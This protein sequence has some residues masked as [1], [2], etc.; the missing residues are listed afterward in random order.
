[1]SVTCGGEDSGRV[2]LVVLQPPL[3]LPHQTG[4]EHA[5]SCREQEPD[6][7]ELRVPG[8]QAG[9]TTDPKGGRKAVRKPAPAWSLRADDGLQETPPCRPQPL[10]MQRDGT[11]RG[12]G[13]WTAGQEADSR[14]C[15]P[16]RP[17][18]RDGLSKRQEACR[19]RDWGSVRPTEDR[20]ARGAL[21]RVRLVCP[22]RTPHVPTVRNAG[23]HR[24]AHA[25]ARMPRPQSR[26]GPRPCQDAQATVTGCKPSAQCSFLH[27]VFL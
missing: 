5:T 24:M 18:R 11:S 20:E 7:H 12:R 2:E 10:D 17:A 19:A 6:P 13:A 27:L 4:A 26:D 22:Q 21:E 16:G 23:S 8:P 3:P 9:L 15:R 1:M 25:L 14:E